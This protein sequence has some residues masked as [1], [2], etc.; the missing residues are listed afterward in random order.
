MAVA[1]QR[2]GFDQKQEKT[3]AF[4]PSDPKRLSPYLHE[5]VQFPDGALAEG[6]A[7]G[8][9][10]TGATVSGVIEDSGVGMTVAVGEG[11]IVGEAV[12]DFVGIVALPFIEHVHP[13]V[14]I[15]SASSEI[16]KNRFICASPFGSFSVVCPKFAQICALAD[17]FGICYTARMRASMD[18]VKNALS[19]FDRSPDRALGQN[20]CID[21]A[22]LS[23][24]VDRMTLQKNVIEI[25]PGLGAL[26]ELLLRKN[27]RVTAIE[28][29]ARMVQYL[30]ET[31]PHPCL[32]LT[33][34]DA[35]KYRYR[36]IETPFS[37]VGNLP[38]YITTPL[39]AAVLKA[40][41]QSFYCMVQKEAAER[42]FAAPKADAYGPL[43]ILTELYYDAEVMDT[44]AENCFYPSP[45]VTSVFV[46]MT[47]KPDAPVC[48]PQKLFS[49]SS[50]LLNMRRKTIK[51]NLKPYANA[52]RVLDALCIPPGTRAETLPP[53]T[54]LALFEALQ[55]D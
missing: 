22:R 6:E 18:F 27:V 24:C 11:R 9:G 8:V 39:C 45:T 21:G 1:R 4:D 35:L 51:N 31:M 26:T 44:F 19:G 47:K 37:V 7:S 48:D 23:A 13:T 5:Q 43:S 25:G 29:D 54:V 34:G 36:E 40:L 14:A 33:L 28:K 2:R 53:E 20:F 52:Q 16:K 50:Q 10:A 46:G 15:A 32:T 49:F 55:T 12:G 17:V 3:S 30:T 42:F 41:P 38:Y